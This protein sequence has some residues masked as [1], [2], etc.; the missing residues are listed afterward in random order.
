[1]AI[2]QAPTRQ[3]DQTRGIQYNFDKHSCSFECQLPVTNFWVTDKILTD[4]DAFHAL[5]SIGNLILSL[6]LR[7]AYRFSCPSSFQQRVFCHCTGGQAASCTQNMRPARS[8]AKLLRTLSTESLPLTIELHEV[9]RSIGS[10]DSNGDQR[11]AVLSQEY[12]TLLF[13][14]SPPPRSRHKFWRAEELACFPGSP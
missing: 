14:R 3:N 10:L 11:V 7:L 6:F 8:L 12:A 2:Q 4:L 9:G 13:V 5:A 1:M